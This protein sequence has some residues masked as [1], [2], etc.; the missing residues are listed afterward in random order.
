MTAQPNA[1]YLGDQPLVFTPGSYAQD[2]AIT[3]NA[4]SIDLD[5]PGRI[6]RLTINST[7]AFTLNVNNLAV[8]PYWASAEL[9]I[10][11]L[12]VPS[13][14]TFAGTAT[15]IQ[16]PGRTLAINPFATGGITRISLT[17]QTEGRYLIEFYPAEGNTSHVT[18][19]LAAGLSIALS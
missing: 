6:Y 18:L 10:R 9:F 3:S 12:S 7:A 2:P 5:I 11:T 4:A 1:I 16:V 14:F 15:G 8:G 13:S 17:K 19:G